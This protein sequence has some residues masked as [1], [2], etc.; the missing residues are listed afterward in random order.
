MLRA[1]VKI[2]SSV[3]LTHGHLLLLYHY[4]FS[5]SISK[6]IRC[7]RSFSAPLAH[8]S[9]GNQTDILHISLVLVCIWSFFFFFNSHLGYSL[10]RTMTF[11]YFPILS[12][13]KTLKNNV[14]PT[15]CIN[16][17][18]HTVLSRQRSLSITAHTYFSFLCTQ[19]MQYYPNR[20]YLTFLWFHLSL[21]CLPSPGRRTLKSGS[22]FQ[23][24]IILPTA[25]S[26]V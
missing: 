25:V 4:Y 11:Q 22:N 26:W 13:L 14:Y 23:K 7:W 24:S 3:W 2:K 5:S 10:K 16:T 12:T 20:V 15:Q 19:A 21:S 6:V 17:H 1:I 8:K 18:T 9:E